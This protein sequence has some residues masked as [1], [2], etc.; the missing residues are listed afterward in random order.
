MRLVQDGYQAAIKKDALEIFTV[1]NPWTSNR[2]SIHSAFRIARIF[3]FTKPN[4]VV[5]AVAFPEQPATLVITAAAKSTAKMFPRSPVACRAVHA[6]HP[7][8]ACR[9]AFEVVASVVSPV[10]VTDHPGRQNLWYIGADSLHP[11]RSLPLTDWTDL[12]GKWVANATHGRSGLSI[13]GEGIKQ[14]DIKLSAVVTP[15]S[16]KM[17]RRS[18][19]LRTHRQTAPLIGGSASERRWRRRVEARKGDRRKLNH[20]RARTGSYS[21]GKS[22]RCGWISWANIISHT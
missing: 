4:D 8:G 10:P 14:S 20:P 17:A 18:V 21:A 7:I 16:E 15:F 19:S 1:R 22:A 3:Q 12:S 6:W 9:A 11:P 2:R 5:E 13:A